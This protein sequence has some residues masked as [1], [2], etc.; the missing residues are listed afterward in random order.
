VPAAVKVTFRVCKLMSSIIIG[1]NEIA[2]M[3]D[4]SL[5]YGW[6]TPRQRGAA[7]DGKAVCA[8]DHPTAGVS[9]GTSG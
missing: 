6:R 5:H 8:K 7:A 3:A 4:L 2:D 9:R 1:S